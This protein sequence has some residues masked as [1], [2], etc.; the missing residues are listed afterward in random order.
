MAAKNSDE[1]M[2][3][4]CEVSV[5][6]QT[7]TEILGSDEYD[8]K[9]LRCIVFVESKHQSSFLDFAIKCPNLSIIAVA[10]SSKISPVSGSNLVSDGFVSCT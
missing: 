9:S 2:V 5:T 4:V 6:R 7:G 10:S 1:L 3:E 8:F